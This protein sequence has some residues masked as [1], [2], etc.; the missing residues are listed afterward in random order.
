MSLDKVCKLLV[1]VSLASKEPGDSVKS[2]IDLLSMLLVPLTLLQ[3]GCIGR[4]NMLLHPCELGLDLDSLGTETLDL[5]SLLLAG[6]L[7][8]LDVFSD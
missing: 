8:S 4:L 7:D 5:S 3:D 2:L 1:L 6:L